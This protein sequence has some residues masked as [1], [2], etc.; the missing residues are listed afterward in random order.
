MEK[1]GEGEKKRE[2][3]ADVAAAKTTSAPNQQREIESLFIHSFIYPH[4]S[5]LRE[6]ENK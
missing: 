4:V 2:M 3:L 1:D 5:L 6:A